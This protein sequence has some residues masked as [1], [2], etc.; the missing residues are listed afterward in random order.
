MRQRRSTDLKLP[1]RRYGLKAE[2][3]T[4]ASGNNPFVVRPSGLKYRDVS[5]LTKPSTLGGPA[6]L[7]LAR[8]DR[9][10]PAG[11]QRWS[12]AGLRRTTGACT[13]GWITRPTK[14]VFALALALCIAVAAH[15]ARQPNVVVVLT[16][17]QGWGDLSINGNTAIATPNIDRLARA[18]AMFDRYYVCA[19][20]SPTRAEFL[21]GRHHVRSGVYS[22][23]AGGE[24]IDPDETLISEIFKRAGYKTAAFG[25]W[26]SG[27]QYPYH[28]NARG[29]DEYYGFCSGHW[30]NYYSPMLDHNG[31]MVTGNGYVND[32]FTERAMAY[33]EANQDSPFFVYLPLNTPHSPMQVPDRWWNK[34]KDMELTQDHRD[35]K[36]EKVGHTRAA[37]AMCENIDWNVGRLVAK[38]DELKLADDTIVIYFCD[39]GPNGR[40]WNGDMRGRKG[41]TDEGGVRSPLFI[42]WPGQIEP[43]TEVM[44]ICSAR[45]LLPTLADLCG[46]PLSGDKPL[47]GISL[48]PLLLGKTKG[49]KDRTLIN[50]WKD[51]TSVRTERY[52]LDYQGNLYDM[53]EDP[54]QYKAIN[55]QVPETAAAL[56]SISDKWRAEM[57]VD[58]GKE[59]DNRPFVVGHPGATITQIPARDGVAIGGIKRSCRHPND[60]YFLN[61]TS[62]EDAIEWHCEVG[63]TGKH[64][65]EIFYTCPEDD[66]GSTVELSFNGAKLTRRITEAHNPPLFGM[67][68]DRYQRTESYNKDFKR[69]TFGTI[70]LEKGEGTL[71]LQALDIPGSQVMDFRLMLLTRLD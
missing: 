60:S 64:K 65:V 70:D 68:R 17:D 5:P 54:G 52:R 31:D 35:K 16:D 3:Q 11:P 21:T 47:D 7:K 30:G 36:K 20:C 44:P 39:N 29:F 23:S 43:A 49:W 42:R 10:R 69:I 18:G 45:D 63:Q 50:H 46:V 24:R 22:T 38:L 14:Q 19:V 25:K 12:A 34:F 57:L 67:Q 55:D 51:R 26:H 56:K 8:E 41:S 66:V 61:W 48:K 9:R 59:H 40:R 62:T 37:L 71:K 27:M 13:A 15:A 58:Y 2:L 32:D 6:S 33:I 28:P 1:V 53:L 4:P